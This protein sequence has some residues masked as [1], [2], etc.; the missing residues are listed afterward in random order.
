MQHDFLEH[1]WGT[2]FIPEWVDEAFNNF[3]MW[4]S[5]G[6]MHRQIGVITKAGVVFAEQG[7]WIQSL[8]DGS[9]GVR[10]A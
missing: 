1:Q 8:P 7:D 5:V 6:N 9:Y 2:P 10:H 3:G 4:F